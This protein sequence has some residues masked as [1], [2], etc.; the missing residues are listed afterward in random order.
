M[1]F[2]WRLVCEGD[3]E[4]ERQ[5][6]GGRRATSII[7]RLHLTFFYSLFWHSAGNFLIQNI[8]SPAPIKSENSFNEFYFG[9]GQ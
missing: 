1:Q 3:P 2:E 4:E 9:Q 5:R 8:L 7:I 6:F